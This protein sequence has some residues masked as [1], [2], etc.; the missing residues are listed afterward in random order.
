MSSK[1]TSVKK[2]DSTEIDLNVLLRAVKE[3]K[4]GKRAIRATAAAYKIP[5]TNLDRYVKKF[6]EEVPDF[7]AIPD[8]NLIGMLRRYTSRKPPLMVSQ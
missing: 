7:S 1:K 6:D 8:H 4:I 5:R 2:K 3:V